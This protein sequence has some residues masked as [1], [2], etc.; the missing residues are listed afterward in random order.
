MLTVHLSHPRSGS[1]PLP[2]LEL[3]QTSQKPQLAIFSRSP[4]ASGPCPSCLS[5][6]SDFSFYL[7]PTHL[8]LLLPT[9]PALLR[10]AG[11]DDSNRAPTRFPYP[12]RVIYSKSPPYLLPISNQMVS[13]S[14]TQPLHFR[15]QIQG[16][17][18]NWSAAK[19]AEHCPSCPSTAI[20]GAG[21]A[22]S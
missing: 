1:H 8:C 19:A 15:L 11:K 4:A 18:G 10:D 2:V 6:D 12:H 14:G 22:P 21:M 9:C 5:P 7:S 16:D 20:D 13:D 3:Q 17:A